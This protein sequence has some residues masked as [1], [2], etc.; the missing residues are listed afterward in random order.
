MNPPIMFLCGIKHSGK[1]TM[2]RLAAQRMGG[3]CVD[4]DDLTLASD[5]KYPTIRTMFQDL[6]KQAFMDRE[7]SSLQQYINNVHPSQTLLFV[8]L[9]GGACDNK[10]L[11]QLA[12]EQGKLVYLRCEEQVLLQRILKDGIPPFLN[13]DDVA[14]SFTTLF[15][16]RDALYGRSADI[17]V[18]LPDCND[19]KQTCSYLLQQLGLASGG[20]DGWQ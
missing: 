10:P 19:P 11:M 8:S 4:S 20:T 2:A 15:A 17:V 13:P 14:G 12:K 16:Q 3:T 6:G 7:F 9:G 5:T 18:E 1:S